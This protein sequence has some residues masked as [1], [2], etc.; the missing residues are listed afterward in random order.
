MQMAFYP[1]WNG[2]EDFLL[3][4]YFMFP[5]V[6]CLFISF[7]WLVHFLLIIWFFSSC[8]YYRFYCKFRPNWIRRTYEPEYLTN[9]LHHPLLWIANNTDLSGWVVTLVSSSI[10]NVSL[11]RSLFSLIYKFLAKIHKLHLEFQAWYNNEPLKTDTS[12]SEYFNS[13][14]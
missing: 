3:K 9:H 2:C 12:K 11:T 1:L 5:F 4:Q 14:I 10:D 6:F 7:V 8:W 13:T